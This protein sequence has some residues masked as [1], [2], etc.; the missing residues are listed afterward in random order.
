[1]F[2]PVNI[3]QNWAFAIRWLIENPV[4]IGNQYTNPPIIANT[5]PIDKT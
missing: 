4:S 3:I 2:T 1:M 5:A